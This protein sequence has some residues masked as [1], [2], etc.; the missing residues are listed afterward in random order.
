MLVRCRRKLAQRLDHHELNLHLA[1]IEEFAVIEP[2]VVFLNYTL[3]FLDAELRPGLLRQIFQALKPGGF[4]LMSEK[5]I[6]DD[7]QLNETVQ[8]AYFDYKKSNGYSGIG[9]FPQTGC[10]GRRPRPLH[11]PGKYQNV[12]DS[13]ILAT[14]PV[15]EMVQLRHIPLL[16]IGFFANRK[17][18][19]GFPF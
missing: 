15:A 13:R 4:L 9:D 14:S 17:E 16:Q 8:Q 10:I 7:P 2:S 11:C 18:S 3:Q 19:A 5:F 6:Y 12:G 1:R